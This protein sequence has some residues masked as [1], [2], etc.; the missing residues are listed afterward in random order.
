[1][2]NANL[3]HEMVEK[4]FH[5]CFVASSPHMA[6]MEFMKAMKDSISW[7]S[8]IFKNLAD[9]LYFIVTAPSQVLL[10]GIANIKRVSFSACTAFS[11]L[12]ITQCRLRSTVTLVLNQIIFAELAMSVAQPSP[13]S[14]TKG[15]SRDEH[16]CTPGCVDLNP[17]PYPWKMTRPHRYI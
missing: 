6:P 16:G 12:P 8:D 14:Q 17:Y 3:P 13:R 4:E 2:S 11:L 9:T 10:F 5:V 1:M 7:V 15:M